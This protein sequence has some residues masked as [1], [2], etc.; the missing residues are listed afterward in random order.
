MNAKSKNGR[1]GSEKL[2]NC[3][4][5]RSL[6]V[7]N[8]LVRM[9]TALSAMAGGAPK[10]MKSSKKAKGQRNGCSDYL[11]CDFEEEGCKTLAGK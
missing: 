3:F 10:R 11:I 2:T 4:L 7:M 6:L 5:D 1:V 8:F 9:V